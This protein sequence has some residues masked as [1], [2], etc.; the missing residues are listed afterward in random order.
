MAKTLSRPPDAVLYEQ[1]FYVWTQR[2]AELLRAGR[3]AELDLPHLI[4]EVEDLG[5]SQRKDVFSRSQQILQHFLKLQFSR[6]IEPRRSWQQTIDDQRDELG[7]VITPTLRRNL[8][9]TLSERYARARRRV[10][11]DFAR[12]GESADL[13]ADCPYAVD[14]VLDPDWLPKNRHGIVD[15][16]GTA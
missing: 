16:T 14:Q 12:Y 2:Q 3:F 15:D 10:A 13:P 4:E 6:A 1:D 9:Q 8:E 5:T 7:L 11:K